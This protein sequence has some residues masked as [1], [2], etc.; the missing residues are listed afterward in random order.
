MGAAPS[1]PPEFQAAGV[2][3]AHPDGML[4]VDEL[5]VVRYANPAA[6]AAFEARMELIVGRQFSLSLQHGQTIEIRGAS[7]RL[8]QARCVPATW[9]GR[10]A[11]LVCLT[12]ITDARRTE[13][14]LKELV[15][16]LDV[17]T[18]RAL[19][20][21]DQLDVVCEALNALTEA[22]RGLHGRLLAS[23]VLLVRQAAD[24]LAE[25]GELLAPALARNQELGML[26]ELLDEVASELCSESAAATETADHLH[27]ALGRLR[28]RVRHL[29]DREARSQLGAQ[30]A[31]A[32]SEA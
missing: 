10:A 7:R 22:A 5:G 17:S 20:D 13:E 28:T 30:S 6:A 29:L 3:D 14:Q 25:H 27:R 26:P 16:R 12:D 31:D 19:T 11:R 24:L 4:I 21:L 18:D 9:R 2:L 32:S 15:L 8:L 1:H 23:Q